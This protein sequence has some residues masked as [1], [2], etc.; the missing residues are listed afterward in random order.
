MNLKN[1][2]LNGME[3]VDPGADYSGN[4]VVYLDF[5]GAN[6]TA[7]N[8]EALNIHVG[9]INVADSGLDQAGINKVI[10][11]LNTTF[12]GSGVSFTVNVPAGKEYS[13]I[14]I[15]GTG[16]AFAQYGSAI[17][18]SETIDAGNKIKN[19]NAYVLADK[20]ASAGQLSAVIAHEAGHLLGFKHENT[21]PEALTLA[22]FSEVLSGSSITVKNVV[23]ITHGYELSKSFPSWVDD[24]SIA[25]QSRMDQDLGV[26]DVGLYTLKAEAGK[27][28]E[29]TF[30]GPAMT[31]EN[32]V[33]E[34]DWSS[35]S[36]GLLVPITN[37]A[38]Y[39]TTDVAKALGKYLSV[40]SPS[41]LSNDVNISMIGHSRGGSLIAALAADFYVNYN[42][43]TDSAT[44]LDPHPL[45]DDYGFNDN[46]VL[47]VSG[48]TTSY[49]YYRNDGSGDSEDWNPPGGWTVSTAG[50]SVVNV[51]LNNKFFNGSS[52]GGYDSWSASDQHSDV[53]LWYQGTID[54]QGGFADE[55]ASV[56]A[57]QAGSW[58]ST[59]A[60]D[61]N[62]SSSGLSYNRND[63]GYNLLFNP[64]ISVWGKNISI[65]D[66]DIVPA[67]TDGTDFGNILT[68]GGTVTQEFTIKDLGGAVLNLTGT[69]VIS[70]SNSTD[71]KIS[72]D[73]AATVNSGGSTVF[74]ITFDPDSDGLKTATVTISSNDPDEGT[75]DFIIQGRGLKPDAGN[76][77]DTANDIT[78]LD[79]WV[80]VG[81]TADV[82][83]LTM[84][85]AGMLTL[86]L[87][88]LSGNANLLLLNSAGTVLKASAN[89]GITDEAI[90][91]VPLSAGT[92]YVK[93]APG[94]GV[95]DAYYTLTHFEKYYPVDTAAND[96][97]TAQDISNPDNWVGFGDSADVYKLTMTSAGTLTLGLTGLSGNADLSLLNSA[98]TVLKSSAK[99]GTADEAISNVLLL[100][101][102]YYV[103]VA[104]G[105]GVNDAS[106]TLSNTI[107]YCPADT[108]ANDYKT[109]KDIA[110]L[111]NCVGFGDSADVYKL[112]M[113]N[114]GMLTLGLTGLTGNADLS[115]LNSAGT[116]LKNSA[117]AG[118]ADEAITNVLLQAGTYYVK[119]AAGYG[120]NDV[121]YTLNNTIKYSP[122]DTAA[123]DYKTAQDIASL[124][125]WVGFGDSTD[126]YKL[127]MTNAGML[128]LGLTGLTGNADLSLLNSAGTVLKTSAKTGTSDEAIT[129]AALLAGTYYVKVAAGFGVNDASY[130]LSHTEK[131]SPA[132][133][134]ANTW[135]TAQDISSLDNWVGFGDTADV[136]KLIMTNA[137]ILTLGLTG[138]TGNAD[139]SLLNSAGTV[140]KSSAKAGTADEAISNVLL[141]AGSYYVKVAAG[142]GVND[143][144]YTLSD[145]IKYY[146]ADTAA[147]DYKIAQDIS[148]LDNRV[149]FGDTVDVYK[150]TMTNAGTLTLGLSGL[151]GNADLSLLNS[152]GGVLKSSAKAGTA[153]E[154]INGVV[155]QAG[156]YY[157]K[158]AAGF[159]VNDASYTLTN[160]VSYF[161]GDSYDKGG[162]TI[163]AAKLVDGTTQTGW[164]GFGD[165]D[166]YYRFDLA[167]AAQE[168]LR[169]YDITG[170]NADLSLYD[171]KGTLL[172]KSAKLG[173]LEDTLTGSLAAGTYYARVNAVSGNIDYKLDFNK[174]SP[175]GMLAG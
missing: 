51:E 155:L 127:T 69:P 152:T 66:G 101:G 12:A 173:A 33:V 16:S 15:G 133:T 139:L 5:K 75:Y 78:V 134:A 40:T 169:L 159:G 119:V 140:L 128:T 64:E 39:S 148:N 154:A 68:I 62:L 108:A 97:K 24:M 38:D 82:Y 2:Q 6:N 95:N 63:L 103:K 157:V 70:I 21:Q 94:T 147:N 163:A 110:S 35:L 102:T 125:N 8:N 65:T 99:A 13:T 130:T 4:Q 36:G 84:T 92:Y 165:S 88:G 121:S 18:L 48:I 17:G 67:A 96:Y 76:T 111:D 71:F 57:D 117:K 162:N 43:T 53:H 31:S 81:D 104:A 87:T 25:I 137:G 74:S 129:N 49:N 149:G 1:L 58:Y 47:S 174:N 109:A 131:Y 146:P 116:V 23:F 145:S 156:T 56:S 45:S 9:G 83:K 77:P 29:I 79:N 85:N 98:G 175:G 37:S 55:D 7:Y 91:S 26:A 50:G 141:L 11:E 32:M 61:T 30:S 28:G 151:S 126:V 160:Q 114:A 168:T 89:T 167:A 135:Q 41:L 124:D 3:L 20:I 80:G 59:S 46:G 14:Y 44:F 132:D 161:P 153:D 122:A 93:V 105:F 158:V 118:T 90:N 42:V 113:T 171:A 143:A 100:A 34:V 142:Y 54:T 10:T 27:D 115:L 150:L 166:D 112:T 136:Y 164:V 73:P 22:D 123:N 106:Y 60:F 172:K 170:G 107:K 86:G 72:E 144:G 19:D 52:N 138:L 120:V